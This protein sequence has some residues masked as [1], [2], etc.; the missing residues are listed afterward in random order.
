MKSPI[1]SAVQAASP[2]PG[3]NSTLP[4]GVFDSG[5]GGLTVLRAMRQCMPQE[6]YL[7]LGDTARLPYGTKSRETIIRY[8]IQVAAKLISQQIK[9]LVV[10]CNTATSAALPAL[11]ERYPGVPVV[12]VVEPGAQAA[13]RASHSG[14]IAVIA[15]ESTVRGGSYREAILR[16]RPDARVESR[17]CPLFVPMAEEGL[18]DGPLVEGIAARYLAPLFPPADR[19][20]C[21]VLGCTHYPL[22]APAIRNVIGEEVILVD[23]AATTA[24]TVCRILYEQALARTSDSNDGTCRF[25][26]TDDRERFASI[27][28]FF[29]DASIS[30]NDVQLVD[31]QEYL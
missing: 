29:L 17:A 11:R 2:H 24:E 4:I 9:I 6:H 31:L 5:V 19:P 13:C 25:F 30:T 26:T 1:A 16:R 22:L 23:S 15:T 14:H 12:G 27:G 3:Q 8:A 20:D 7:Y 28:S 21:L 10:A 18:F